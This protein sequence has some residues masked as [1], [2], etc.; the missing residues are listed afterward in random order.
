MIEQH[1]ENWQKMNELWPEW[2]IHL[3]QVKGFDEK[4]MAK[5]YPVFQHFYHSIQEENR[6]KQI[7][8]EAT[9]ELLKDELRRVG[10]P[11]Q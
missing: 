8:L 10:H 7:T 2:R 9:V 11:W 1:T 3:T 5:L 4:D 6:Q